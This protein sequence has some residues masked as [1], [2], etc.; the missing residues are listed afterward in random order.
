MI[1]AAEFIDR[2]KAVIQ[3]EGSQTAFAKKHD[4]SLTYLNDIVRERKLPSARVLDA[5][6][7]EAVTLYRK[8]PAA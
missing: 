1:D 6:G 7:Y 8:K 4:V 3:A 2:L 5:L